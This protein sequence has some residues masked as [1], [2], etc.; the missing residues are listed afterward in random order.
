MSSWK[1]RSNTPG[2]ESQNAWKWISYLYERLW[3]LQSCL[4]NLLQTVVCGDLLTTATT[5]H[6][7]KKCILKELCQQ[8]TLAKAI[9]ILRVS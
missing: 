6:L 4:R 9:E 8:F 1:L 3:T 5:T 2:L 7:F